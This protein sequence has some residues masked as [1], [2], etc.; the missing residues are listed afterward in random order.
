M[1]EHK[2]EPDLSAVEA[3]LERGDYG[4]S[5]AMLSTL[6]E[7]H[8]LT[9]PSGPYLRL[10][11]VT[12]WMGQGQ[13]DKALS[14]CRALCQCRDPDSRQQARQLLTILEAPSLERP[15]RWSIRL[16]Q[17]EMN[18]TGQGLPSAGRRR[19]RRRK[20]APPPP[21][22]GP[23]RGPAFGFALLVSAVLLGLTVLL[24]GCVRID[25]DLELTGPDRMQMRWQIQSVHEQRLPWLERF[26]RSLGDQ[27]PNLQIE[28]PGPGS[29]ILLTTATQTSRELNREMQ[30][31]VGLAGRSAGVVLPA[32]ELT[33]EERNWLIGVY[34]TL[35]LNLDLTALPTI[36]DL[37]INLNLDHGHQRHSLHSGKRTE[38]ELT[39][40]RWSPLGLGALAV[41]ILL[42]ASVW[43]QSIRRRLF[44]FPALP[45]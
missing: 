45:S 39:S 21:P 33:L 16:P 1:K 17:L 41:L 27:L 15:E 22:T 29:G 12:A 26:E 30:R 14:T 8:P 25:A 11:M 37:T 28:H 34:Q 6:A 3:A 43:L 32:P 38:I 2:P 24:S 19:P 40:W 10:L 5:L 20:D 35:H 4:Q 13:D 44:G 23:T 36:P 9:D 7:Q 18:G 31:M 42:L